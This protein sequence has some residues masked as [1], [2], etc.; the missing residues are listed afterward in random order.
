MAP[1]KQQQAPVLT[2]AQQKE[3]DESARLKQEALD[4]GVRLCVIVY[5][6]ARA[7]R[8]NARRARFAVLFAVVLLYLRFVHN[9]YHL[10]GLAIIV[11]N[12]QIISTR[13]VQS[14]QQL[15]LSR[16]VQTWGGGVGAGAR[17]V[18]TQGKTRAC[19]PLSVYLSLQTHT[20]TTTQR[21]ARP[22]AATSSKRAPTR[23]TATCCC[24]TAR[25]RPPRPAA[26]CVTA[27]GQGAGGERAYT[28]TQL[29]ARINNPHPARAQQQHTHQK[30][31]PCT[32][33]SNQNKKGRPVGARLEK[34]RPLH[35]VPGRRP[36][37]AHRHARVPRQQV[38][39]AAPAG[40]R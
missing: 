33:D 5:T 26:W 3:A 35:R 32:L 6:R 40:R 15:P 11:I 20:H 38:H 24:S 4:L 1:K 28:H 22:T 23:R 9:A 10:P 29:C 25:S 39:G 14:A 30:H 17:V 7:Q 16:G 36:P 13:A 12:N 2:T 21:C 18:Q 8:A 34:P 31:A 27:R 37:Q 19:P